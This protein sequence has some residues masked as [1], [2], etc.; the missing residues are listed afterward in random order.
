MQSVKNKRKILKSKADSDLDMTADLF[1]CDFK[2]RLSDDF[3][4]QMKPLHEPWNKN[5]NRNNM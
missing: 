5:A 1:E 4:E 2:L 3:V